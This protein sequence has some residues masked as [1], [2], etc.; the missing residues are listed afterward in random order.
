MKKNVAGQ[1]IGAQLNSATDG[2]AI[3][4]AVSVLVTGDNG[5]QTAGAGT[6]THKGNG[7][8]NYA[9]TQAETN[10]DHIAFVFTHASG[11]NVTLNVYTTFPQ[12]G[13]SYARLGAPAGASIA[14]DIA[15]RA[16]PSD[17]PSAATT[18]TAVRTEL[19]TELARID[20]GIG[21]RATPADVP[22]AATVASQVRTELT[23]ELGRIDAAVST[24]ASQA[25]VDT[26]DNLLDTEIAA[27]QAD[28]TT[29]LARLTALRAA[30][31]DNLDAAISTR[32]SQATADSIEADT[33]DIQSR[34]PAALI[35]GRMV[36][37][38]EVMA[39][40]ALD[41]VALATNAG[42]E[43][44]DRILARH[45]QGG[46][47]GGRTVSQAMATLRNKVEIVGNTLTVY[48]A[49]DTTVLYTALITRTA[50]DPISAADPA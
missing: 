33:Q 5:T 17:V 28:V 47:D 19:A 26:V 44:A 41:N 40:D 7:S 34:L 4:S 15:T 49:D 32:A 37:Y 12:T 43:I 25:S 16:Q 45:I 21:T 50:G 6:L 1:N 38:I 36:G 2:S 42:Q 13:D 14:A 48:G 10:F 27:L 18:A 9:P 46:S 20:A 3:T 22:S 30:A 24:R 11:V 23:T 8:W 39:A 31:I 35:A 29:L